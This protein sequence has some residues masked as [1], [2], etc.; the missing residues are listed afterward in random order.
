[1]PIY[2]CAVVGTGTE[3]DPIRPP[4]QGE[5]TGWICLAPP[6][7]AGGRGLLYLPVASLDPRIRKIADAPTERPT[8][9]VRNTL[10]NELGIT[11]QSPTATPISALIAE[12]MRD[13]GRTNGTRWGVL[14]PSKARQRFEI[15][16]GA[17]GV[18]WS[19]PAPPTPSTQNLTETWPSDGA[20]TSGQDLTWSVNAGGCEV[21]GGKFRADNTL[22]QINVG[23]CDTTLDTANQFHS[24]ERTATDGG[25]SG[26]QW[27]IYVRFADDE[28]GYH[29]NGR[30]DNTKRRSCFKRVLGTYTEFYED[31]TDPGAS[32]TDSITVDGSTVSWNIGGASGSGTDGTPELTGNLKGGCMCL[33]V[34]GL[35]N[36]TLDNNNIKDVT[37]TAKLTRATPLGVNIGMGWRM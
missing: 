13:H 16:L 21:S 22:L 30:R 37:R 15:H 11:L 14:L 6:G 26:N 24:A 7:S 32:S 35:G 27:R 17:L 9:Q 18:I 36:V 4:F 19:A 2:S 31:S 25:A 12:V 1:M 20:I 23:R 8:N 3:D 34:S 28:N 29:V 33:A 10:Q 5:G